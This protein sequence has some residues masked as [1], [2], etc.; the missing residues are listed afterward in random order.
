MKCCCQSFSGGRE[1]QK[2]LQRHRKINRTEEVKNK[3]TLRIGIRD[4]FFG[5]SDETERMGDGKSVSAA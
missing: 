3:M 2:T 4:G 5:F 1:D